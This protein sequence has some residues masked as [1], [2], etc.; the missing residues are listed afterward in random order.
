MYT[1][2]PGSNHTLFMV[3]GIEMYSRTHSDERADCG[4]FE[5]KRRA[6]VDVTRFYESK[7]WNLIIAI[8]FEFGQRGGRQSK[9]SGETTTKADCVR[10]A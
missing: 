3:E 5:K 4:W 9:Y 7:T 8:I 6:R 1:C 10:S 2:S